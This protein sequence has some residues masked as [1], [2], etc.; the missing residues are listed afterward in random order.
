MRDECVMMDSALTNEVHPCQTV[1]LRQGVQLLRLLREQAYSSFV[2]QNSSFFNA[3]FII[4]N[5]KFI[6]FNANSLST[7][8]NSPAPAGPSTTFFLLPES[9]KHIVIVSEVFRTVSSHLQ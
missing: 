4:F 1:A 7:R 2:M 5:A 3:K 6:I 8:A 9:E